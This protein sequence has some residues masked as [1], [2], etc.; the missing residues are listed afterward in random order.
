[1]GSAFEWS[2]FRSLSALCFPGIPS[3]PPHHTPNCYLREHAERACSSL[4]KCPSSQRSPPHKALSSSH[5]LCLAAQSPPLYVSEHLSPSFVAFRVLAHSPSLGQELGKCWEASYSSLNPTRWGLPSV[6]FWKLLKNGQVFHLHLARNLSV[7][8][9]SLPIQVRHRFPAPS[10]PLTSFHLST[11]PLSPLLLGEAGCPTCSC[12][13]GFSLCHLLI[14]SH[15]RSYSWCPASLHPGWLL[16]PPQ[17][18]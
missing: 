1:M 13:W 15:P 2:P 3:T 10:C 7:P 9:I 18:L 4:L 5:S 17:P 16:S 11:Y 14:L 12:L 6:N 8:P